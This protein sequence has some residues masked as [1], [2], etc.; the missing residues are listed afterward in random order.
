VIG[1]I[2]ADLASGDGTTRHDSGFLRMGRGALVNGL[3]ET[4]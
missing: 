1:E 3:P 4:P 2:L